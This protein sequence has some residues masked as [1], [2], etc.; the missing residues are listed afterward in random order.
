MKRYTMLKTCKGSRDGLTVDVFN[1]G[2]TYELSADLAEQ[3][4]HQ[5]AVEEVG[6]DAGGTNLRE[7]ARNRSTKVTGPTATKVT[8]PAETK[9]GEAGVPL[10][11]QHIEELVAL[12]R[13]TYGLDV[14]STMDEA[15]L[16]DMI[17]QAQAEETHGDEDAADDSA[18]PAADKKAKKKKR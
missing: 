17:E 12:A 13:D 9:A 11:T 16:R 3:F 18:E 14:D 8:G 7:G 1:Q 15:T 10:G 4:Y 2:E 5:A 6:G